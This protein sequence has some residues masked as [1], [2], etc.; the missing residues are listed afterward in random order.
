L[1]EGSGLSHILMWHTDHL[2]HLGCVYRHYAY[3]KSLPVSNNCYYTYTGTFEPPC[4]ETCTLKSGNA[5]Y[6]VVQRIF[7]LHICDLKTKI[8]SYMTVWRWVFWDI[9]PCSLGVDR[10]FRGAN[11]LDAVRTSETSIYSETTQ[12]YIPEGCHL[13]T[14]RRENL[15]SHKRKWI[16]FCFVWTWNLWLPHQAK[17]MDNTLYWAIL[18][19]KRNEVTSL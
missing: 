7:R 9:A 6:Q 1:K 5:C 18:G 3:F 4:I 13:Y 16:F 19:S 12:R 10:H 17:N 15:K 8:S 11:Y 14:R 2:R